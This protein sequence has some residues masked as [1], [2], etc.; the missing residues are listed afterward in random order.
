M[1]TKTVADRLPHS[2]AVDDWPAHVY[3]C[4]PSRGRY[5]VRAHRDDL[6]SEGPLVRV[7]RGLV[8]LGAGYAAW[9][10][11]QKGRVQGFEIA[12]NVDDPKAMASKSR[13]TAEVTGDSSA[14]HLQQTLSGRHPAISAKDV[15]DDGS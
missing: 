12:P 1:A 11:K 6:V 14:A 13:L 9:L 15:Q 10:A 4:R 3:P 8:V 2:W 5:I 7:G